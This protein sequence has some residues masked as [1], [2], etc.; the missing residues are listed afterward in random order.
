[1]KSPCLQASDL[2]LKKLRF[3]MK[4]TDERR[5]LGHCGVELLRRLDRAWAQLSSPSICTP[6]LMNFVSTLQEYE[7]RPSYNCRSR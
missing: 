7:G 5:P 6:Y 3:Q 2:C 4:N 1:M